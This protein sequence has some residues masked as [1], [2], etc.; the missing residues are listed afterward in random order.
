MVDIRF[1][2]LDF[3]ATTEKGQGEVNKVKIIRLFAR[4]SSVDQLIW[5]AQKTKTTINER[6][7]APL[8]RRHDERAVIPEIAERYGLA[9]SV[10]GYL[11]LG[12]ESTIYQTIVVK[13]LPVVM[14]SFSVV[15]PFTCRCILPFAMKP[16]V[17]YFPGFEKLR[18]VVLQLNHRAWS[19]TSGPLFLE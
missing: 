4:G 10:E 9:P 3:A 8:L 1:G 12:L 15:N 5:E 11:P 2:R 6:L 18:D 14:S 13:P 19:R 16:V 7:M 17:I